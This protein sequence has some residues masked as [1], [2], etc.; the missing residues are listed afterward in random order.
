MTMLPLAA[1]AASKEKGM[2]ER[3]RWRCA[4]NLIPRL[5]LLFFPF[6]FYLVYCLQHGCC[7]YFHTVYLVTTATSCPSCGMISLCMASVDLIGCMH[8]DRV[9]TWYSKTS[10]IRTRKAL[11]ET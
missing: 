2:R 7:C 5:F 9:S 10:E 8:K 4:R 3:E 11:L 6:C 1:A